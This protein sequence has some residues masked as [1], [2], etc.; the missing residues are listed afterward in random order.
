MQQV[1]HQS[2]QKVKCL[3]EFLNKNAIFSICNKIRRENGGHQDCCLRMINKLKD[4]EAGGEISQR[5]YYKAV[6]EEIQS[7]K[8]KAKQQAQYIKGE[9]SKLFA[10]LKTEVKIEDV[11]PS[12]EELYTS[13]NEDRG[14]NF[15]SSLINELMNISDQ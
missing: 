14:N 15:G 1:Q 4:I 12:I 10:N 6:C 2:M 13:K 3:G 8:E 7:A 9:I 5:Y 11:Q